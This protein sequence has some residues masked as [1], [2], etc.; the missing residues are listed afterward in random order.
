MELRYS[1]GVLRLGEREYR[2]DVVI[3]PD[4]VVEV[5][6]KPR[7][8]GFTWHRPLTG[9][10][11]RR[12]VEKCRDLDTL[13]IGTGYLGLLPLDEEAK[14]VVQELRERGVEVIVVNTRKAVK[15]LTELWSQGRR[16]LAVLHLTC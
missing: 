14:R 3:Y 16:V 2:S 8:K 12:Y 11:L 10:E 1:F 13:L 6:E 7:V 5:R 4:H 15:V 9:T